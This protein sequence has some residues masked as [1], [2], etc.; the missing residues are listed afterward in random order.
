MDRSIQFAGS[1]PSHLTP[2][3]ALIGARRARQ[4]LGP[5]VARFLQAAGAEV[6][7]HVGWRPETLSTT[8]DALQAVLDHPC[9]GY[10]DLAELHRDLGVHGVAIL[11]PPEYHGAYLDQAAA[12]G[13]HVLCEKPFTLER[14]PQGIDLQSGVAERLHAFHTRGLW[15]E[16][17]CQWPHVLPSLRR[18]ARLV[19]VDPKA[20]VHRF[21]MGL[22]PSA[23][24]VTMGIDSLSHPLS[25]LQALRPGPQTVQDVSVQARPGTSDTS[26]GFEIR[27][28]F[29]SPAPYPSQSSTSGNAPLSPIECRVVLEDSPQRPRPAWIQINDLRADRVVRA[30]DYAIFLQA[31]PSQVSVPD[32]LEAHLQGFVERLG[33]VLAG[34]PVSPSEAILH[35]A[36]W[37]QQLIQAF[38]A[39]PA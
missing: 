8:S 20:S 27:F 33:Q 3:I 7:A 21:A 32:P 34:A 13:L 16:E 12:L 15:V 28:R 6:C 36:Q 9:P 4:G 37:M 38:P 14:G 19:G 30:E 18:L 5:F 10:L 1:G 31:G 17:N 11:C 22:S 25:V 26:H 29:G 24:G 2:R 35:R 39:D 23:S